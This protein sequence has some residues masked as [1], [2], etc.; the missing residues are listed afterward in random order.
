MLEDKLRATDWEA[1]NELIEE[2]VARESYFQWFKDNERHETVTWTFCN[3]DIWSGVENF[4]LFSFVFLFFY[5]SNTTSPMRPSSSSTATRPDKS[6]P[7]TFE[8]ADKGSTSQAHCSFSV[9]MSN[10]PCSTKDFHINEQAT[11]LNDFPPECF[12]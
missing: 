9:P 1:T 6:P 8:C 11:F 5:Q 10:Q 3:D 2:Q 7:N 12:G 4:F